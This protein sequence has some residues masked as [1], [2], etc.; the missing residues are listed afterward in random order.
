ME[1]ALSH[2]IEWLE[3]PQRDEQRRLAAVILAKDMA[4]LTQSQFFQRANEFFKNIFKII[5]DCKTTLR[6]AA[7]EALRA[8]LAVTSQRETKHKNEW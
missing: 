3:E 1:L 2:C 5:C 6:L 8:A 7:T 4:I